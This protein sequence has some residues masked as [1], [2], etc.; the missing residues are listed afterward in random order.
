MATPAGAMT[1]SAKSAASRFP[2][3]SDASLSA[4]HAVFGIAAIG[5]IATSQDE[6]SALAYVKPRA[7]HVA[8]V[9]GATGFSYGLAKALGARSETPYGKLTPLLA[10]T[11]LGTLVSVYLQNRLP[12]NENSDRTL[13]AAQTMRAL[14]LAVFDAGIVYGASQMNMFNKI[15]PAL[16]MGFL[17]IVMHLIYSSAL[18]TQYVLQTEESVGSEAAFVSLTVGI[19]TLY[20][21]LATKSQ[22]GEVT[23]RLFGL[24]LAVLF[25]AN[26]SGLST[27][28]AEDDYLDPETSAD[29][30]WMYGALGLCA[31][32]VLGSAYQARDKTR[33]PARAAPKSAE[34]PASA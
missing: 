24:T 12:Y 7:Y 16:S 32:I 14:L 31:L 28:T 3:L 5:L 21:L 2:K 23:Q 17:N 18:T 30:S 9:V 11:L 8:T 19:I 20:S 29:P 6:D 33:K 26:L 27:P 10:T 22:E 34:V 15:H 13:T 1:T 25:F 4:V